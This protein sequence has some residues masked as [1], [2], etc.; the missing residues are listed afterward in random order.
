M[1]FYST[2]SAASTSLS[3]STARS[4]CRIV[5]AVS[6]TTNASRVYVLDF[7][8]LRSAAL[9][10]ASPGRLATVHTQSVATAVGST[11][12]VLARPR[13]QGP[14]R[15][16]G[17]RRKLVQAGLVL[18]QR[19]AEDPFSSGVQGGAVVS[20]LPILATGDLVFVVHPALLCATHGRSHETRCWRPPLQRDQ[21]SWKE[22]AVSL[23]AFSAF[24]ERGDNTLDR[25]REIMLFQVQ[26]SNPAFG[27]LFIAWRSTAGSLLGK[28]VSAGPTCIPR[29]PRLTSPTSAI[30]RIVSR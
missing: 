26:L 2:F 8:E 18:W 16:A 24:S 15:V 28:R 25:D 13:S 20:D 14:G 27:E 11:P 5:R 19:L 1:N 29:A 4:V 3:R 12:M 21:T 30:Y 17:R 10:A 23:S 22:T 6:A 7:P 9:R